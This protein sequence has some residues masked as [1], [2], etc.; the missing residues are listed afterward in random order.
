MLM[1]EH[2]ELHRL[3]RA[4]AVLDG[5]GI[6]PSA[7]GAHLRGTG[8]GPPIGWAELDGVLGPDD[9]LERA[10][11]HRLA[12]LVAM[13]R[14]VAN[15]SPDDAARIRR[16]CRLLAL[17]T[18][19]PLHPGPTWALDVVPGGVLDLGP[20]VLGVIPTVDGDEGLL[21]L[22]SSIADHLGLDLTAMWPD[23]LV[24]A[25][26]AGA[27]AVRRLRGRHPDT[28]L[29]AG[30][31]DVLTLLTTVTVRHR[32]AGRAGRPARVRAVRRDG[33]WVGPRADDG[34]RARAVWLLTPPSLRGVPHVLTLAGDGVAAVPGG[35]PAQR[36]GSSRTCS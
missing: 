31:C 18:H 36:S 10:P 32:L 11:R 33:A 8:S 14:L 15:P 19:H 7:D 21:P 3:V 34:P 26:R 27:A 24:A 29:P 13:R 20:G 12:L 30:G 35:P 2:G 23:L 17:P 28:L 4:A 25:E 5:L 22:P 16:A 6:R 9:P 1:H